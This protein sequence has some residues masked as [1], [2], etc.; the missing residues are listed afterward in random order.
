MGWLGS[1]DFGFSL[2]T[3]L[4]G[5]HVRRACTRSAGFERCIVHL[6]ALKVYRTKMADRNEEGLSDERV[7]KKQPVKN[8]VFD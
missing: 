7:N 2:G 6:A 8:K 1:H 5:G 3:V 4:A